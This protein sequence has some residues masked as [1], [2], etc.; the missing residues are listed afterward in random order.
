M[1]RVIEPSSRLCDSWTQILP[2]RRV[3]GTHIHSD[4]DSIIHNNVPDFHG[5]PRLFSHVKAL[6]E[7]DGQ[8]CRIA[9]CGD[10]QLRSI[11]GAASPSTYCDAAWFTVSFLC[12]FEK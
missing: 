6:T 4:S 1:T 11:T 2:R 3:P 9:I 8:Q 5:F 7:S 12:W 10:C